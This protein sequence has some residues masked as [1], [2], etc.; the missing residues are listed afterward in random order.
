MK[1]A[2]NVIIAKQA[3][4][5]LPQNGF[6]GTCLRIQRRIE[7]RDF[8]KLKNWMADIDGQR[9][10]LSLSI[11]G[12]HDCVT[13]Y[14]QFAHICK[15]QDLTIYAQLMLGIRALDIR[16]ESNGNRLKMVHG[17]AKVFTTPNKFGKQ[18]DLDYVLNACYDFL[19][20]NPSETILFQ[21]KNDSGKENEKCF[22]NLFFHYIAKAPNMWFCENRV[23]K[24]D[25]TR[26]KIYL[27]R[28][29]KM[30]DR[31][32][33]TDK[34]TGLDFSR[35]I[36]QDT[37]SPDPLTLSTGGTYPAQFVVQDRYKYKPEP[38]WNECIKPFLDKAKPFDGTYIIDY[39]STA[40]GIKGPRKNAEHINP[41]FMRY[42]LDPA[43][44]YGAI[45]M[46][47]PTQELVMKIINTNRK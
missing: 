2:K 27:I 16:V 37:I 19:R 17:V 3:K 33:F 9:D 42:P 29:C 43:K 38:R 7:K 31:A 34:N 22:D 10:L 46:D 23:P 36:E 11:P 5:R 40:G 12:T 35:W 41:Q 8:M 1:R 39:L 44:Y 4:G 24:L 47:F 30:T 28:R 13:K 20:E 32:E 25:K 15:T 26:G 45:Y 6:K 18:M 14:V 21:F